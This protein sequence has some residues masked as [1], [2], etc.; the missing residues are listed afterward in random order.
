MP[1]GCNNSTSVSLLTRVMSRYQHVA[2][3]VFLNRPKGG[4][5]TP[6]KLKKRSIK[7]VETR[8]RRA[9]M[10]LNKPVLGAPDK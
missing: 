5:Q 6:I 4:A 1:S 9:N 2:H 7:K 10:F 8:Q 3:L